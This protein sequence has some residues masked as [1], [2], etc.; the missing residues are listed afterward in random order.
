MQCL[1]SEILTWSCKFTNHYRGIYCAFRLFWCI[2]LFFFSLTI[3]IFFS[4][5]FVLFFSLAMIFAPPPQNFQIFK[6][7]TPESPSCIFCVNKQQK[8]RF[9]Y[10]MATGCA[11]V[12]WN[13]YHDMSR[14]R[15]SQILNLIP[16]FLT[17]AH[18]VLS[19]HVV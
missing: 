13:R 8:S 9:L 17:C 2:F 19:Y 4:Y 14:V 10:Q 18:R 6:I 3:T 15:Y 1:T 7:Y 5:T 16:F 11:C 12:E